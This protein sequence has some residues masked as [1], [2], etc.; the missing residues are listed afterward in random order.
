M[1]PFERLSIVRFGCMRTRQLE[2]D[3]RADASCDDEECIEYYHQSLQCTRPSSNENARGYCDCCTLR[4]VR[5][6]SC[7]AYWRAA[8]VTPSRNAPV[9]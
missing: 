8:S 2:I 9:I 7:T 3:S 4:Q 1:S 6:D 5:G